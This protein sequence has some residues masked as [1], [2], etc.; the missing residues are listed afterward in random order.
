MHFET[1][2]VKV[3][4]VLVLDKII[5]MP[6]AS[7]TITE[8]EQHT[9]ALVE[10]AQKEDGKL[11]L[12]VK[13]D[14]SKSLPEKLYPVGLLAELASAVYLSGLAAWQLTIRAGERVHMKKLIEEEPFIVAEYEA[15]GIDYSS[16]QEALTVAELDKKLETELFKFNRITHALTAEQ[17]SSL[18]RQKT[19]ADRVDAIVN[20]IVLPVDERA[21]F[22]EEIYVDQRL[23]KLVAYISRENEL[24]QLDIEMNKRTRTTIDEAQKDY[25]LREKVKTIQKE[26]GDDADRESDLDELKEKIEAS[27]M[28][29]TAKEK[30]RKELRKMRNAMPLSPDYG[31]IQNY[32]EFLVNLPWG[33][34][35]TEEKG[36]K[37]ASDVLEADH[38]GLD[39]VK[40]RILEFLAVQ[41]LNHENK[42]SILCLAGPPGI[43]KTSL[44]H[45]I[46]SALNRD[47]I[48]VSLGGVQDVAE[49]R[50][51][52]RTY[53][54]AIPGRIMQSISDVGSANPVFLLDE[55]DKMS[56]DFRGDPSAALLEA[57]DPE[58][59][60]AFSDHFLEIPF[61]LSR[62]FFITTVNDKFAIPGPLRDRLEI[63]DMPSYTEYEK[64]Q[65]AKRYLIKKAQNE[66]GLE[67]EDL[68]FTDGA[69]REL[70]QSY[71]QEAGVREL[72]RKIHAICRK[73]AKNKFIPDKKLS[74]R[75]TKTNLRNYLGK[76]TVAHLVTAEENAVG[77]A[78]GMAWT[79]VGGEILQ[80]ESQLMPGSGKILLTGQMG[81]VMR[82]S[83][84]IALTYLRSI[85]SHFDLP[86]ELT[87]KNDI[88]IHIPEGAVPKEGP[89]AGVTLATSL[90]SAMTNRLLRRDVAMTGE[91][92]LH[93]KVLKVGGIREKVMAAHR[94]GCTE[95]VLPESCLQ[96]VEE[97]PKEIRE[98]LVFHY[99][100]T[101]EEV[102]KVAFAD[103]VKK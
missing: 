50:G 64:L 55:I 79:S 85:G 61:D 18:R 62:V 77:I 20:T 66:C 99:V 97:I 32:L 1:K 81:D 87:T 2:N 14:E 7:I 8:K 37:H 56:R 29:E 91:I 100:T 10:E 28:P 89:S 35:K 17:I 6:G 102:W 30:A 26:L 11:L 49:I 78:T 71:T 80:I 5:P 72:Q 65:I 59:N 70:I 39:K 103:E 16:E 58:Q 22:L 67:K 98:Q 84:Q 36:L 19:V 88:H 90:L 21:K 44:A 9:A 93:G 96:D 51:H 47:F 4:P 68:S 34:Y 25:F 53:V 75:V 12:F 95:I 43:G 41:Y 3:L 76:P 82:E 13:R 52:R 60:S 69:I 45:S 31:N 94:A 23:K 48:R 42:G 24:I 54:G 73:A 27:L 92:T 86:D 57:L 40:A 33:K 101:L 74:N 38:Y 46:A 83:A 63:I 15:V